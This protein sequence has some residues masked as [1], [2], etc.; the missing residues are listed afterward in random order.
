MV[1]LLPGD[2]ASYWIGH[3]RASSGES[4]RRALRDPAM[5]ASL[6][7]ASELGHK[8]VERTIPLDWRCRYRSAITPNFPP[9]VTPVS[10]IAAGAVS[11]RPGA[12]RWQR[13]FLDEELQ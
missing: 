12:T 4:L 10:H 3:S 1:M 5:I 2:P 6:S 7:S 13:R 9:A 8:S 11:S